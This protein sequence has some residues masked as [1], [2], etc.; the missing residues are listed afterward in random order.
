MLIPSDPNSSRPGEVGSQ[1][2]L[3]KMYSR[4][5]LDSHRYE[6]GI[7]V[8]AVPAFHRFLSSFQSGMKTWGTNGDNISLNFV[9]KVPNPLNDCFT[10]WNTSGQPQK[11]FRSSQSISVLKFH[12]VLSIF[13]GLA[14]YIYI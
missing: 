11:I 14:I 9:G 1:E 4:E 6:A 2:F 5:R 13:L 12:A 3:E 8:L 10:S 7:L